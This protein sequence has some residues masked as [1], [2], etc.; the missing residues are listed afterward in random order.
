MKGKAIDEHFTYEGKELVVVL[1]EAFNGGC[2]VCHFENQECAKP[3]IE[4]RSRRRSDK[5]DVH[6]EEVK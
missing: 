5:N 2:N 4:C 1:D 6:F 3:S